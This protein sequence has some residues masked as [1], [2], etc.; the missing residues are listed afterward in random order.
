ME[1]VGVSGTHLRNYRQVLT[2]EAR[3]GGVGL[4][5]WRLSAATGRDDQLQCVKTDWC[6]LLSIRGERGRRTKLPLCLLNCIST[7]FTCSFSCYSLLSSGFCSLV[8]VSATGLPAPVSVFHPSSMPLPGLLPLSRHVV[9]SLPC[10][11][12][13]MDFPH[14]ITEKISLHTVDSSSSCSSVPV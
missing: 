6:P 4:R 12:P 1:W 5:C 2:L 13:P 8:W 11:H 7:P 10:Q 9:M 14:L 3:P